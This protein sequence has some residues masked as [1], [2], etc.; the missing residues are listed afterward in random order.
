M[1]PSNGARVTVFGNWLLFTAILAANNNALRDAHKM[2][3]LRIL[4]LA[5]LG[6]F[7]HSHENTSRDSECMNG[8][9]IY[10]QLSQRRSGQKFSQHIPYDTLFFLRIHLL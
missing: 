10:P 5:T 9:G 1:Q 4:A 6:I 2:R 3:S 7:V 8:N